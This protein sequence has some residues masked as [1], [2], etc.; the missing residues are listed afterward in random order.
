MVQGPL[1]AT[2]LADRLVQQLGG[3]LKEF[4]F[5]AVRPLFCNQEMHICGKQTEDGAC[6]VWAETPAGH[7]A[8]AANA[9]LSR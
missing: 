2:L 3:R 9:V 5:R 4:R 6:D 1:T 8:M 7:P